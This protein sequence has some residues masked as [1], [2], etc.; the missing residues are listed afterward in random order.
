MNQVYQRWS[1]GKNETLSFCVQKI[2]PLAF[3]ICFGGFQWLLLVL[4][5]LM[6]VHADAELAQ[7]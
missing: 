4:A 2:H 6:L 3:Q 5:V 7:V 1:D